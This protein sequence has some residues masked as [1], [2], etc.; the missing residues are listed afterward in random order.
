MSVFSG[1]AS[2]KQSRDKLALVAAGPL[3]LAR[4]C[5]KLVPVSALLF[6]VK[7]PSVITFGHHARQAF[8]VFPHQGT[9]TPDNGTG[10]GDGRRGAPPAPVPLPCLFITSVN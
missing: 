4:G 8:A 2:K 9:F 3:P 1:K 5:I 6:A 10:D 7:C